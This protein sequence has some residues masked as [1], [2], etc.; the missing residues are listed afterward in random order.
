M[1]YQ[2]VK[3]F[4]T[5]LPEIFSKYR[6][7]DKKFADMVEGYGYE[8]IETPAVEYAE[9]LLAKGNLDLSQVKELFLFKDHGGRDVGLRFDLTAPIARVIGERY[10]EF[11]SKLPLRWYYFTRMWRYENPQKGRYREFWQFG[12]ELI[13]SDTAYADSEVIE[14]ADKLF[15]CLG[16]SNFK[17]FV[18]H[19]DILRGVLNAVKCTNIE[20]CMR[21]IDKKGKIEDSTILREVAKYV[22]STEIIEKILNF[23]LTDQQGLEKFLTE[24]RDLN[25]LTRQGITR[26]F[27]VKEILSSR[28]VKIMLD[29]SL[30]R[31]FDYYT[32]II[33]EGY[34]FDGRKQGGSLIGGGRYDSLIEI[35]GGEKTPGVGFAIGIDRLI[36][37]LDRQKLINLSKCKVHIIYDLSKKES[38]EYAYKI[39]KLLKDSGLIVTQTITEYND[40][41]KLLKSELRFANNNL[42]QYVIIVDDNSIKNQ[43]IVIKDMNK[44]IQQEIQFESL[45]EFF[46]TKGKNL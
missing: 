19:R 4:R 24:I 17:L 8:P 28:D 25:D 39:F 29:P 10:Y 14:I 5:L 32:G 2:D 27:S 23:D 18:S 16:L 35:F 37:E 30:A 7:I 26:I 43:N 41:G 33:F 42:F 21:W 3:G 13:G 1:K 9:T 15:K 46:L 40:F 34:I 45:L 22:Q 31:G 44:G 36:D 11:K 12:I 6:Y 20:E 38:R